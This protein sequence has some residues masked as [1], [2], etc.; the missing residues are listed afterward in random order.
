MSV[1]FLAKFSKG[2]YNG[3]DKFAKCMQFGCRMASYYVLLNDPDN[4]MAK[5]AVLLN[6]QMAISR[7]ALRLGKSVEEMQKL[8]VALTKKMAPIDLALTITTT[9]G[10]TF[11]WYY[12]NLAFLEKT[13]VLAKNNYGIL[14]NKFRVISTVAYIVQCF[15]AFSKAAANCAGKEGAELEKALKTRFEAGL[16][17]FARCCDIICAV[18]GAKYYTTNDGI[19]GVCGLASALLAL[20]KVVNA[21]K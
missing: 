20:R 8:K 1:D 13:K 19:Q 15:R 21:T 17:L 16:A 11:R 9:V 4:E 2:P 6:K 7:K 10:M 14:S 3:R 18:H 12:D 5:K